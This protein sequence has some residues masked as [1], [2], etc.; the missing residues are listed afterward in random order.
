MMA[1]GSPEYELCLAQGQ[2][3]LLWYKGLRIRQ[4]LHPINNTIVHQP[5][6]FPRSIAVRHF[7]SSI[8]QH[9]DLHSRLHRR[10]GR[11]R[12]S[13]AQQHSHL[14]R[15]SL[16]SFELHLVVAIRLTLLS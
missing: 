14:C 9:E 6:Q 12:L 4:H 1:R 15:T 10:S 7:N 11:R 8:R 16:S 5:S 2:C 3:G 13:S